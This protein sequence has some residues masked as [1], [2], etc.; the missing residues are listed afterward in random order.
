MLTSVRSY[1]QVF[2]GGNVSVN[3]SNGIYVDLAPIIGYQIQSFK[4]GLSP[5][6]SYSTVNGTS[7]VYSFG[8]RVF[9]EYTVWQGI[10]VHAEFEGQN[11]PVGS[12]RSWIFSA[13]IGVGY[14][15][16]IMKGVMLQ[17]SVLW[18]FMQQKNNPR[19][20]PIVRGGLVYTL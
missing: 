12:S 11:V 17:G 20:N 2:T 10:F 5:I 15:Y 3:Y 1:S 7:G 4:V 8:G 16:P 14:E 19:E 9:T 6:G 18:D 13:P